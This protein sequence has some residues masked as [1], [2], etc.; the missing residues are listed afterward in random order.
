MQ[1]KRLL[2][3]NKILLLIILLSLIIHLV[4]F[5]NLHPS[6]EEFFAQKVLISD[7]PGYQELALSILGNKDFSGFSGFR[8]PGYP[9]FIA[10]VYSIFGINL[11][12]VIFFQILFN[13]GSLVLVY[14]LAKE[15]LE[16]KKAAFLACFF[17]SV[18]MLLV[19]WSLTVMSETLFLFFLLL[20]SL[21][22]LRAFRCHDFNHYILAAL[23]FGIAT[24]IRP[25]LQYLVII[26]FLFILIWL[27]CE[28]LLK[29]KQKNIFKIAWGPVAFLAIFM[30]VLSPWQ[31]RNF[32]EYNYYSLSSIAGYNLLT[33]NAATA[34]AVKEN[35]EL[36]MARK[37][38]EKNLNLE[39]IKNP[40]YKSVKQQEIALSYIKNNL[41][42]YL[43]LHFKG[44]VNMF[45]GTEKNKLMHILDLKIEEHPSTV[46]K[47]SF[48]DRILRVIETS[49][50][51]FFISPILVAIQFLEYFLAIIG[52]VILCL[53]KRWFYVIFLLL[54]ILYFINTS[55]I[56]ARPRFKIPIVPFYLILSGY[57]A[58]YL[59]QIKKLKR[60]KI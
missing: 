45:L 20:A 33:Y 32:Y 53:K 46:L 35:I 17:M 52:L 58:Y 19:C 47:E 3:E 26:V 31:L 14:F 34:K 21:F 51:E 5:F 41:K 49:K 4:L 54:I 57:G 1:L 36:G 60:Q 44:V 22:L 13:F 11:W 10:L 23:F 6:N 40:F 2:S 56:V 42:S 7:G 8:T 29:K 55:G 9:L 24:L 39:N 27:I 43:V 12:P 28:H 25:V 16:S 48:K 15:F 30:L 37:R 18:E 59:M 50:K 38:L